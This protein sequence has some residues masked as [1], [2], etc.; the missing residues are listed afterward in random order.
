MNNQ[1]TVVLYDPYDV[2]MAVSN[3]VPLATGVRGLIV[4]GRGDTGTGG[5]HGH[6]DSVWNTA[7]SS[8]PAESRGGA[9]R[10]ALGGRFFG[11]GSPSPPT[12]SAGDI[13]PI[14][15]S[16][17]SGDY[18][19][20]V[21]VANSVTI[22]TTPQTSSASTVTRVAVSTTSVILLGTNASRRGASIFNNSN[23]TL[24]LKLG[25]TASITSGSESFTTRVP[26]NALYEVPF[27]YIGRIDGIWN[28]NDPNGEALI[29]EL[30]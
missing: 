29:T 26:P 7:W 15:A 1:T 12:A 17:I 9:V 16:N 23:A 27:A 3:G 30:G 28:V 5:K 20:K 8:I 19:L 25:A 13:V 22:T 11:G 6:I 24:F 21:D 14:G 10:T 18:A 4:S 2:P